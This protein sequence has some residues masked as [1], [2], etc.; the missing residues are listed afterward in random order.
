MTTSLPNL[1]CLQRKAQE[2]MVKVCGIKLC[3]LNGIR[4]KHPQVHFMKVT[5]LKYCE[6]MLYKN[7]IDLHE[8]EF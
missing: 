6:T 8:I 3:C 4:F 2:I 1:L 7:H 5:K